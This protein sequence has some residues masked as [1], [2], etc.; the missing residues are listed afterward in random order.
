MTPPLLALDSAPLSLARV[1]VSL[2][3]WGFRGVR[4]PEQNGAGLR[5]ALSANTDR[6][7]RVEVLTAYL[8]LAEQVRLLRA[9]LA[10]PRTAIDVGLA[11]DQP[12]INWHLRRS[13]VP[14]G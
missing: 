3:W 9:A 2:T 4:P 6:R 13:A 8:N 1:R 10:D 14:E 12:T 5:F 11:Q 7:R